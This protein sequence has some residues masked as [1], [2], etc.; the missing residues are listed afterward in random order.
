MPNS[1]FAHMMGNYVAKDR[2]T[3]RTTFGFNANV[4]TNGAG[5]NAKVNLTAG[6]LLT[7]KTAATSTG[8]VGTAL[9][10]NGAAGTS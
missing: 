9:K 3:V 7:I 1:K 2:K 4:V 10:I 6:N 5:A 8:F